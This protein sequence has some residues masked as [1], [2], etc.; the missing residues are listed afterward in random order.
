MSVATAHIDAALDE[1]SFHEFAPLLA[2]C[3]EYARQNRFK[4]DAKDFV[5]LPQVSASATLSGEQD[6]GDELD[7]KLQ[8]RH[9]AAPAVTDYSERLRNAVEAQSQGRATSEQ[10][11]LL[12]QL[13]QAHH[14]VIH[15]SVRNMMKSTCIGLSMY[16]PMHPP[17]GID[18]DE[19]F[20]DDV[21]V[22]FPEIAQRL[23]NEEQQKKNS[24]LDQLHVQHA[25][26]TASFLLDFA[27]QCG[28]P[29]PDMPQ[30][31]RSLL[32][33]FENR[34]EEWRCG[35]SADTCVEEQQDQVPKLSRRVWGKLT[36]FPSAWTSVRSSVREA[37]ADASS[38]VEDAWADSRDEV[39]GRQDLS[40]LPSDYDYV[41][42]CGVSWHQ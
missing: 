13:N 35:E 3:Q 5:N 19:G 36:L 18:D 11:Q 32:A 31:Y 26:N 9:F 6:Q 17:Q 8:A 23:Y 34:I 10:Q 15:P 24:P 41:D 39:M 40:L 1:E 4:F 29:L 16:P 33:G 20:Y 28:V 22:S 7:L 38:I 30:R 42:M 2:A 12:D 14:F 27:E 21:S 37:L 25:A